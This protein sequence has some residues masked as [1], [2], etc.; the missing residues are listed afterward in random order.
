[1]RPG[2][3]LKRQEEAEAK[4]KGAKRGRGRPKSVAKKPDIDDLAYHQEAIQREVS[5]V[6]GDAVVKATSDRKDSVEVLHLLKGRIARAAAALEFQRVEMQKYGKDTGQVTSRQIAAL[7]E[8]ALIELKI[9]ELGAQM[10]DLRSEPV[11]KVLGMF[12]AKLQEAAKEV[13]PEEQFDLLFNRLETSLD[14]WEDEAESLL[15]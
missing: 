8:I 9:R 2:A 11:Q 10:L 14:G 1:M 15:R 3:V 5:F 13:L 6:D 4:A 7:K 12:I